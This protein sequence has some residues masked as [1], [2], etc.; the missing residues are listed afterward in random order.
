MPAPLTLNQRSV[1]VTARVELNRIALNMGT[2]NPVRSDVL[3]AAA[4]LGRALDT[5]DRNIA[6]ASALRNGEA[7]Q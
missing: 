1:I 7:D 5:D 2:D 3:L 6:A 4:I